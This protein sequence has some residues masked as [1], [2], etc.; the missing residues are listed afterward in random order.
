MPKFPVDPTNSNASCAIAGGYGYGTGDVNGT[1]T[2]ALSA[3]FENS[4]GGNT[5]TGV[6]TYQGNGVTA[7]AEIDLMKK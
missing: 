5:A 7:M 3:A 1:T 4:N 2:A 6:T